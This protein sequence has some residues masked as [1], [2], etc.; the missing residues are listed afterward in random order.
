MPNRADWVF[1]LMT[2]LLLLP[3]TLQAVIVVLVVVAFVVDGAGDDAHSIPRD[4]DSAMAG[5]PL[6]G[7]DWLQ[8]WV[9]GTQ[10]TIPQK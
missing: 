2:Q 7:W 9:S 5:V 10:S 4:T 1:L 3:M 6:H 8:P